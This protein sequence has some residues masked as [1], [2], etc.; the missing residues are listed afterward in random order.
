MAAITPMHLCHYNM[1]NVSTWLQV[2]CEIINLEKNVHGLIGIVRASSSEALVHQAVCNLADLSM[3]CS[4]NDFAAI[5]RHKDGVL[6]IAVAVLEAYLPGLKQT[7]ISETTATSVAVA[8]RQQPSAA[9]QHSADG[10][11]ASTE[12]AI[13]AADDQN[14][15][16]AALPSPVSCRFAEKPPQPN[17]T[18]GPVMEQARIPKSASSSVK[19]WG[20]EMLQACRRLFAACLE[21]S[22][23]CEGL[24]QQRAPKGGFWGTLS[25]SYLLLIERSLQSVDTAHTGIAGALQPPLATEEVESRANTG[26]KSNGSISNRNEG[27]NPATSSLTDASATSEAGES[28]PQPAADSAPSGTHLLK[29]EKRNAASDLASQ[30]PAM[31]IT[32]DAAIQPPQIPEY[33]E[34]GLRVVFD[35]GPKPQVQKVRDEWKAVPLREKIEWHQTAT[36]VHV[37][38]K[39]PKGE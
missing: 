5:I 26:G 27:L 4:G 21:R 19:V 30:Q 31:M 35:S 37:T 1:G 28:N 20:Q 23:R 15:G 34:D 10:S 18:A 33:D 38:I 6:A 13:A 32:N 8:A 3:S 2:I 7:E 11:S 39:A 16:A 14:S 12:A 17:C 29:G 22:R 24:S 9:A 25:P 36:E